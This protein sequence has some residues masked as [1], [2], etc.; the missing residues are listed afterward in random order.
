M[1]TSIIS[2]VVIL[3]IHPSHHPSHHPSI[4]VPHSK[5]RRWWKRRRKE[6]DEWQH[7]QFIQMFMWS[8]P[9]HRKHIETECPKKPGYFI[10]NCQTDHV[11]TSYHIRCLLSSFAFSL[12]AMTSVTSMT[13]HHVPNP[14]VNIKSTW[15]FQRVHI[16]EWVC[17]NEWIHKYPPIRGCMLSACP[18]AIVCS[19]WVHMDGVGFRELGFSNYPPTWPQACTQQ[20]SN[21]GKKSWSVVFCFWLNFVSK[22][23]QKRVLFGVF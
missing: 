3:S 10:T 17:T 13:S 2:L 22:W 16:C 19:I 20:T 7:Q 18:V 6:E 23:Q 11:W 9:T 12:V 1:S 5:R 15:R 8:N 21:P 4:Q 14:M